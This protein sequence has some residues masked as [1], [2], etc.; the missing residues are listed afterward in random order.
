LRF[1]WTQNPE[2]ILGEKLQTVGWNSGYLKNDPEL[3]E[4]FR[5]KLYHKLNKRYRR[6]LDL[7]VLVHFI[8]Q[9]KIMWSMLKYKPINGQT[10]ELIRKAITTLQFRKLPTT[11]KVVVDTMSKQLKGDDFARKSL[12]DLTQ[13]ER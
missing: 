9:T 7:I 11:G 4:V 2:V 10:Y 12:R 5:K 3:F 13:I 1:N 6:L 8:W